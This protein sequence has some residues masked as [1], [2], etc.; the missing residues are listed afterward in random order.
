MPIDATLNYD[1]FTAQTEATIREYLG[2]AHR[3]GSESATRMHRTTR[4]A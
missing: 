3:A 2:W 4:S 1:D